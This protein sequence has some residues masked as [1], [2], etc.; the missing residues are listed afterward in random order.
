MFTRLA[1]ADLVSGGVAGALKGAPHVPTGDG[2]IGAPAF[3]ECEK[4]LG[5][6]LVF[7]AV[8]DGPAFL[9]AEVMDWENVRAAEAED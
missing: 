4:F 6:G 8:G 5:T 9:H 2:A 1:G 7:F 3:A